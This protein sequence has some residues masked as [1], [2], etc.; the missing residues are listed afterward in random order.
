MDRL[1]FCGF[2]SCTLP[3]FNPITQLHLLPATTTATTMATVVS[4]IIG[5]SWLS[6]SIVVVAA[7]IFA[8]FAIVIVIGHH[9]GPTV[10]VCVCVCALMTALST[11]NHFDQLLS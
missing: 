9:G 11:H 6:L 7:V 2:C 4:L 3:V 8:Y 1:G 10:C 5:R